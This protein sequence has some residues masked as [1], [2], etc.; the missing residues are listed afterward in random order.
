LFEVVAQVARTLDDLDAAAHA[1]RIHL[2]EALSYRAIP[3]EIRPAARAACA[4]S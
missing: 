3:D 2:A 4:A 1:G